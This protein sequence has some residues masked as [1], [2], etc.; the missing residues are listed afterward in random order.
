MSEWDKIK[1]R[2][3]DYIKNM[4]DT[5]TEEQTS[6]YD[7]MVG[8]LIGEGNRMQKELQFLQK[9]VELLGAVRTDW[10]HQ[11]NELIVIVEQLK[12]SN[13]DLAKLAQEKTKKL[14]EIHEFLRNAPLPPNEALNHIM[15]MVEK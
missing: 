12:K 4:D 11:H 2:M 7:L 15:E 14:E 13:E 6:I 8:G 3:I 1:E 9:S 5:P 10:F